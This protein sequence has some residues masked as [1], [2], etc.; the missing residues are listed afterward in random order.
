MQE[1]NN[2]F[3]DKLLVDSEPHQQ[4]KN[5]RIF[6]TGLKRSE[7]SKILDIHQGTIRRYESQW[8]KASIPKWYMNLLRF[9][10]GDLSA[11]GNEWIETRIHPCDRVLRSHYSKYKGFKPMDLQANTTIIYKQQQRKI[12]DGNTEILEMAKKI[13]ALEKD[14]A[15]L[16]VKNDR[17]QKNKNHNDMVKDQI[18][19]S[20]V[21]EF[22]R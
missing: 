16:S 6:G 2:E 9:M 14:N 13:E 4:A 18:K 12:R 21:L 10:S 8:N 1:F 19:N 20:N 7:I 5:L 22:K 3:L 15:L 17:L 11:Y